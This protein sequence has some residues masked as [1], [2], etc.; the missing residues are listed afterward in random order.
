M[1]LLDDFN[2]DG[3]DAAFRQLIFDR[4]GYNPNF[5]PSEH[6]G[7]WVPGATG[8]K[9]G[10]RLNTAGRMQAGITREAKRRDI[11]TQELR[12]RMVRHP[13]SVAGGWD[14]SNLKT[15]TPKSEAVDTAA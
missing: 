13:A 15:D 4:T 14:T 12:E 9:H 3:A 5:L 8:D 1:L 6:L 2:R 7:E 11:S 10:L